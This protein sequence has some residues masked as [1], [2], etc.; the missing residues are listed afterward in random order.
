M[1]PGKRQ[2]PPTFF[3]Q[4]AHP[5]QHGLKCCGGEEDGGADSLHTRHHH[6]YQ[7]QAVHQVPGSSLILIVVFEYIY[8]FDYCS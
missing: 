2:N 4:R 3:L 8:Y 1:L 6:W 5:C 7:L